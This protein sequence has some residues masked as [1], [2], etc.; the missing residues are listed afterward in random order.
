MENQR[1]F[2]PYQDYFSQ[3]KITKNRATFAPANP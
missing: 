2:N 3:L 1:T